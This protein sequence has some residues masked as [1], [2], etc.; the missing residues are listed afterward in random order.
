ML[1][2]TFCTQLLLYNA[3][4]YTTL[5]S[6]NR[7]VHSHTCFGA[8]LSSV[9]RAQTGSGKMPGITLSLQARLT[10]GVDETKV[11]APVKERAALPRSKMEGETDAPHVLAL[12]KY[13]LP[14]R[15]P[16]LRRLRQ[17]FLRHFGSTHNGACSGEGREAC[18]DCHRGR[19]SCRDAEAGRL[20]TPAPVV[21]RRHPQGLS[22]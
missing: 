22:C 15:P 18:A 5:H 1:V 14:D 16:R 21:R 11:A 7:F 10:R 9:P 17:V 19:R 6:A 2:S 12:A 3:L 4:T 8:V 13:P 20:R